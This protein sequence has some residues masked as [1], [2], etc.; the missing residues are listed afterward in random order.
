MRDLALADLLTAAGILLLFAASAAYVANIFRSGRRLPKVAHLA[1]LAALALTAGG[2]IVRIM[3]DGAPPLSTGQQALTAVACSVL[4][5]HLAQV[6][7]KDIPSF[8]AAA[9]PLALLLLFMATALPG[10]ARTY[11]QELLASHWLTLHVGSILVSMALLV[12]SA[13]CALLWLTQHSMLKAKKWAGAFRRL[14]PLEQLASM[15]FLLATL[16]FAALTLGV[17]TAV[18]WSLTHPGEG[19]IPGV[20]TRTAAALSWCLYAFYIW[21]SGRPAWRGRRAQYLLVFGCLAVLAA[22]SVHRFFVLPHPPEPASHGSSHALL[23]AGERA[24]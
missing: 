19:E 9:A 12:L 3:E 5:A 15:A 10:S 2:L 17:G 18:V 21:A 14:P 22:T 24:S 8:G 4:A 16:G 20:L 11:S 1:T 6:V 23:K 13:G 7:W